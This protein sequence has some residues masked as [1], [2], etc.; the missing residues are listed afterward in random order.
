MKSKLCYSVLR[1][2]MRLLFVLED[3]FYAS[4][5]LRP[6]DTSKHV[7]QGQDVTI[8]TESVTILFLNSNIYCF[9]GK[10]H[11]FQSGTS[12]LDDLIDLHSLSVR[13]RTVARVRTDDQLLALTIICAER[14]PTLHEINIISSKAQVKGL[15]VLGG[16]DGL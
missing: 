1:T 10:T 4:G 7:P 6:L 8:A 2:F 3:C 11:V 14:S 9:A 15:K 12:K 13:Y 5:W 16:W